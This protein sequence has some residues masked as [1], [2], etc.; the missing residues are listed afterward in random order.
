MYL[1]IYLFIY[2]L[3]LNVR[4][5]DNL[6]RMSKLPIN[7]ICMCATKY[8]FVSVGILMIC[9]FFNV[10]RNNPSSG[11]DSVKEKVS[12]CYT[13]SSTNEY[14]SVKFSST[15]KMEKFYTTIGVSV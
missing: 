8:V 7:K 13:R 11:T 10:Y 1:C 5:G 4:E 14:F 9:K 2:L 15:E 3:S 6:K 12:N